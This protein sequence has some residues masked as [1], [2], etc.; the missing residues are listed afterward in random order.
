M[1]PLYQGCEFNRLTR[2]LMILNTCAAHRCTNGFVDELL[3]L[4]QN[5]I[6]PKPNNRWSHYEVKCPVQNLGLGYVTIC[7]KTCRSSQ[8]SG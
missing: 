5:S 3:S 6:L 1:I 4:S 2:T 8:K 7:S